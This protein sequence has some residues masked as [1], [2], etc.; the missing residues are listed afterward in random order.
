[1]K[2]SK[3]DNAVVLL[4]HWTQ[5]HIQYSPGVWYIFRDNQYYGKLTRNNIIWETWNL[6]L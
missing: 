4:N 3:I 2:G 6:S 1:M 5:L